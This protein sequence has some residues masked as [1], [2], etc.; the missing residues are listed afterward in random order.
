[1]DLITITG[2]TSDPS[3]LSII[4]IIAAAVAALVCLYALIQTL[5]K[6]RRKRDVAT[7]IVA[8]IATAAL[9]PASF[10]QPRVE[11]PE[12]ATYIKASGTIDTITPNLN[13]GG[14]GIRLTETP[15]V[16]LT[17]D[18]KTADSLAGLEG[19]PTTLYCDTPDNLNGSAL[20]AGTILDC[21]TTKPTPQDLFGIAPPIDGHKKTTTPITIR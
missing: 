11:S 13:Q 7:L 18:D 21:R 4:L 14:T 3:T 10:L 9:F 17:V 6:M 1:M 5:S 16:L 15:E 20:A 19:H 2:K 12:S 8:A